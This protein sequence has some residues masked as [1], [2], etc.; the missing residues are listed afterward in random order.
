M[1]KIC[2][3]IICLVAVFTAK[4]QIAEIE[5]DMTNCPVGI[6][7]DGQLMK[8]LKYSKM[9]SGKGSILSSI[10]HGITK[11]KTVNIYDG[12]TSNNIVNI[13]DTIVFKFGT[14]PTDYEPLMWEFA[15][16]YS[17]NNFGIGKFDVKKKTRELE[18]MATSVWTGTEMGT[19][20]TTDVTLSPVSASE[21]VYTYIISAAKPGEYCFM[22]TNDGIGGYLPVF[23]FTIPKE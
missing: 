22:F 8:P 20:Q 14:V 23:D 4:A 9:K 7:I 3:F 10:T 16:T 11:T 21:G 1:K 15:T 13:G 5:I 12:N 18:T 19:K 2:L 6:Y 17:P